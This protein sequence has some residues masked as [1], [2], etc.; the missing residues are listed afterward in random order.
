[1][2]LYRFNCF[3]TEENAKQIFAVQ[4]CNFVKDRNIF[5]A[6]A[7]YRISIYE[8]VDPKETEEGIEDEDEEFSGIKLLRAYDDPDRD[9]V[10]YTLAWSFESNGSPIIAAGGVRSVVRI[11]Y[12]NGPGLREKKFIG[13]SKF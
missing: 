10:F 3:I 5:A 9:E 12:I 11:L 7:G 6:A 2:S 1:M 4:F 8:C 13:H